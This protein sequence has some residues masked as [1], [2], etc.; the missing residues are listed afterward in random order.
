MNLTE[1]SSDAWKDD[2][3]SWLDEQWVSPTCVPR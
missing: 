2:A 3:R 1:W